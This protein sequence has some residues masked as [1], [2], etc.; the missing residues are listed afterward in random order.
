[1]GAFKQRQIESHDNAEVEPIDVSALT[2]PDL[3]IRMTRLYYLNRGPFL[4]INHEN[5]LSLPRSTKIPLE[6]IR[7]LTI[8]MYYLGILS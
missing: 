5:F 4:E 2:N 6:L 1:M 3:W 7:D 8:I